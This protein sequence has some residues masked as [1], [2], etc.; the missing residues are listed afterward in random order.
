MEHC[1]DPTLCL[2]I[3]PLVRDGGAELSLEVPCVSD[4]FKLLANLVAIG[5]CTRCQLGAFLSKDRTY[6]LNLG[7]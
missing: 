3:P 1:H 4:S 2:V 5:T 7:M 6:Y